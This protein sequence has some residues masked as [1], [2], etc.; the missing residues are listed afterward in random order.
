MLTDETAHH[1]NG[2]SLVVRRV[3]FKDQVIE[4]GF[5]AVNG[6]DDEIR[7]NDSGDTLLEDQSGRRYLLVPP[8]ENG[9]LTVPG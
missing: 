1:P 7:L 4:G 9:K 2:A 5:Q 6:N 3:E 8:A